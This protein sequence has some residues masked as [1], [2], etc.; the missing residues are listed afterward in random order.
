MEEGKPHQRGQHT[1]G[2]RDISDFPNSK[3]GLER[4]LSGSYANDRWP[5]SAIVLPP[6][7]GFTLMMDRKNQ[8]SI[9]LFL[10]AIEGNVTGTSARYHQFSQGALNGATDQWMTNQQLN[11]FLD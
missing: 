10:K 9:P 11:R 7:T 1:K 2:V 3:M 6:I 5:I 4:Q 8:D